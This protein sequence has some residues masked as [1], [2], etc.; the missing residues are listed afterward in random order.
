MKKRGMTLPLIALIFA[1]AFLVI[2]ST[3]LVSAYGLS[4]F[5]DW[6]GEDI[7]LFAIFAIMFPVVFFVLSKFFSRDEA[8]VKNKGVPAIIAF[9]ITFAAMAGINQMDWDIS[10]GNFF[11]D[12]GI[13]SDTLMAIVGGLGTIVGILL[14]VW[15]KTLLILILGMFLIGIGIIA[16]NPIII[17]IGLMACALWFFAFRKKKGSGIAGTGTGKPDAGKILITILVLGA[18]FGLIY[19]LVSGGFGAIGGGLTANPVTLGILGIIALIVIWIA[20]RKY[21]KK[22]ASGIGT[23]SWEKEK[24][25]AKSKIMFFLLGLVSIALGMWGIGTPYTFGIG[26]I[27]FLLWFWA[28][29]RMPR[30]D[31]AGLGT[32]SWEKEKAQAKSKW[33]FFMLGLVGIALGM[34]GIGGIYSFIA[35]GFF[36]FLWLISFFIRRGKKTPSSSSGRGGYAGSA[37]DQSRVKGKRKISFV[38]I[39]LLILL[40]GTAA[41]SLWIGNWI[42]GAVVG[43]IILL[44]I[45][46]LKM[47]K[48]KYD[49]DIITKKGVYEHIGRHKKGYSK[50]LL[51]L[52]ISLA[53]VGW[54]YYIGIVD[55]MIALTIT[56]ILLIIFMYFVLKR[57]KEEGE[58]YFEAEGKQIEHSGTKWIFF[59]LT[60]AALAG[61]FLGMGGGIILL[62]VAGACGLIFIILWV[63]EIKSKEKLLEARREETRDARRARIASQAETIESQRRAQ[64]QD[65]ARQRAEQERRDEQMRRRREEQTIDTIRQQKEMSSREL[66]ELD[67]KT[68]KI[69]Q[70]FGR[71]IYNNKDNPPVIERGR[72]DVTDVFASKAKTLDP[73]LPYFNEK[74]T[75]LTKAKKE[76]DD[77]YEGW[78]RGYEQRRQTTE[79]QEREIATET[80]L[81]EEQMQSAQTPREYENYRR[82]LMNKINREKAYIGGWLR[83]NQSDPTRA[84]WESRFKQLEERRKQLMNIG[85]KIKD[86]AKNMQKLEK[87]KEKLTTRL[88][89]IFKQMPRANRN[90]LARL[91]E[92]FDD[93]RIQKEEVEKQIFLLQGIPIEHERKSYEKPRKRRYI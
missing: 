26:A 30:S 34:W 4:D 86:T 40:A 35:G 17:G 62:S 90:E 60:A 16:F 33:L 52:I 7:M 2:L 66:D 31:K 28:L 8:G 12:M 67:R 9:G 64:E 39:M 20:I 14:I 36:L 32:Y 19:L 53:V 45:L 25:Q 77:A 38:W 63:L 56:I 76:I 47:R 71:L 87:Q 88:T 18:I 49:K 68:R 1:F 89:K 61:F 46:L 81:A 57:K 37:A 11:F 58:K 29:V 75:V 43:G 85:R 93:L 70:N 69:I 42:I 78:R 54:G 23:Y 15:L 24:A 72:Q 91:K 10:M 82:D 59:L 74:I 50:A 27:F 5:L 6:L 80:N 84:M 48:G 51:L 41:W 3:N 44:I 65:I 92:E 13:S 22:P 55:T 73:E 79:T 21:R 83:R